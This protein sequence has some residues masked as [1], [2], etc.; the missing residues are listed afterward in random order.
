MIASIYIFSVIIKLGNL[1]W[2]CWNIK[3]S[4]WYQGLV[5]EWLNMKRGRGLIIR[6]DFI[7]H[8]IQGSLGAVR[9]VQLIQDVAHI[10]CHCSL[11]DE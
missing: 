6:R 3:K 10:F 4:P 1:P 9:Q 11:L 5:S 2:I 7:F 8:G